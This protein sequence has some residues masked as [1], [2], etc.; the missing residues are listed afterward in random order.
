M[1]LDNF[2]LFV[3]EHPSLINFVRNNEMTW[4]G[5]YE[6]YD[7]Y[8]EDNEVWKE[9]LAVATATA[10][11]KSVVDFMSWFK[12]IDLDTIQNGV[13]NLQR[14]LGVV[15]DLGTKETNKEST[16]YKPR[17]IYKHFED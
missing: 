17:P 13:S 11:S 16:E 2:K 9:Y 3:R 7:L 4:Q 1:S 14:V 6:M 5:F 8:G 10:T 15:Q 12:N